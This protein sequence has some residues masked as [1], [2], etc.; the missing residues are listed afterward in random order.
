M[1]TCLYCVDRNSLTYLMKPKHFKL[2]NI[3]FDKER[4]EIFQCTAIED[5]NNITLPTEMFYNEND[6]THHNKLHD[7][8][9]PNKFH[10]LTTELIDSALNN[11]VDNKFPAEY[12]NLMIWLKGNVNNYIVTFN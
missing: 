3:Y 12:N 5:N 2:E 6:D 9:A 7:I 1:K 11:L 4:I 10:K 8:I